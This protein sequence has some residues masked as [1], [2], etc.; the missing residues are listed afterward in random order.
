MLRSLMREGC[1]TPIMEYTVLREEGGG[2]RATVQTPVFPNAT[3]W[4]WTLDRFEQMQPLW[5]TLPAAAV[6]WSC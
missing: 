5:Y 6:H 4:D 2:G 3:D 1:V